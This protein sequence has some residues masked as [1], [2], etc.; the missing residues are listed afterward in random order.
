MGP[1]TVPVFT[2]TWPLQ[3]SEFGLIL[4]YLNVDFIYTDI[5]ID[6]KP[7]NIFRAP[8]TYDMSRCNTSENIG[9]VKTL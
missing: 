4:N 6:Y 7:Y 3:I 8:E 5:F 9:F 1:F 2:N